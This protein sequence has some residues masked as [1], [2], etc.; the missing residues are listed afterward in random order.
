MILNLKYADKYWHETAALAK[1]C[2]FQGS[3][4]FL[5]ECMK[6]NT[7]S[8]K[9]RIFSYIIEGE[10]IGFCTFSIAQLDGE[11][12]YSPWIDFIFISEEYRGRG[13]CKELVKSVCEYANKSGFKCIFLLTVSHKK[14]YRKMGFSVLEKTRVCGNNPA[15][16]MQKKIV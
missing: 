1:A 14:M 10:P 5:S 8:E 2:S 16:V 11:L 12:P 6:Q 13:Y 3:G 4:E 15:W 7:F 9:D